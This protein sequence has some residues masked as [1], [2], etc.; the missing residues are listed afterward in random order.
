MSLPYPFRTAIS[1]ML[2]EKWI[3]VLAIL[4]MAAGLLVT[5]IIAISVYNFELLT[6]RLPDKFSVV[7]YL[8]DGASQE[9]VK[10]VVN[11][12]RKNNS[13]EN[14]TYISKEEGLNELKA[15]LKETEYVLEGLEENPLPDSIELKLKTEAVT[16]DNVRNLTTA[17]KELKGVDEAEYGER[18]L[19]SIYSLR[20]GMKTAGLAFSAT[21]CAGLLFVC[22]SAIKLL[23]YR[24]LQEIETYKLLG[25]TRAFVRMPFIIEG[26]IMGLGGGLLSFFGLLALYYLVVLEL[27]LALPLLKS[28]T[29]P[30]AATSVL[31]IAG[32]CLG[33]IGAFIAIG[34]IRY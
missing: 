16:P 32:L 12:A 30:V 3:N 5:A 15:S 34:R 27:S 4:T 28:I 8:K 29:F 2:H 13:V 20:V 17:L 21:M 18:F 19:S 31:P 25:A 7:V 33:I 1:S 26:A 14:V 6:R 9:E 22:Y 11:F 24:K 10:N 23:F